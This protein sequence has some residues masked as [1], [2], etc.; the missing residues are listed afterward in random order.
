MKGETL[1]NAAAVMTRAGEEIDAMFDK[2]SV[3]LE[4]ELTAVEDLREIKFSDEKDGPGDWAVTGHLKNYGIYRK[5]RGQGKPSA[6]LGIQI[7]LADEKE[8]E[9]VGPQSLLY[10]MFSAD[11]S[12]ELDEFLLS[13]ALSEEYEL[14]GGCVWEL[15][16]DGEEPLEDGPWYKHP[17]RVFVM[18]LVALN[19]PED[20]KALIVEPT[21]QMMQNTLDPKKLDKRI[22][23]FKERGS[24]VR[25]A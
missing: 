19:T 8:S 2:L 7:K 4:K 14:K 21:K 15:W 9:I 5:G 20:L 18:P 10:V 3:L 22:L 11:E 16:E 13:T 24:E 17:Y 25:L 23:R 6:Y 12:W 1:F